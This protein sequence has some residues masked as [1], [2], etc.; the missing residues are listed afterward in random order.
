MEEGYHAQFILYED[1]WEPARRWEVRI[2]NGYPNVI[3]DPAECINKV[4]ITTPLCTYDL[5]ANTH[6]QSVR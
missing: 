6:F 1:Y 4:N 3:D 5:S 2:D